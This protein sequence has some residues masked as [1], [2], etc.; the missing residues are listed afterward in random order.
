MA[1]NLLVRYTKKNKLII[2]TGCMRLGL[3]RAVEKGDRYLSKNA[4]RWLK[5][6][7]LL[8]QKIDRGIYIRKIK[9]PNSLKQKTKELRIKF[10]AKMLPKKF[11]LID[12]TSHE[13]RKLAM[14]AIDVVNLSNREITHN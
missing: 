10:V 5:S 3:G 2:P 6:S 4:G 14:A 9:I 13:I 8:G 1:R 7:L 11:D 12:F